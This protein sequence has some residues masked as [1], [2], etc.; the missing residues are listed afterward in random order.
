VEDGPVLELSLGK[1][2][3]LDLTINLSSTLFDVKAVGGSAGVRTHQEF[4]G[5]VLETLEFL[6]V[7][8]KLQVPKLLFLNALFICLEVIHQVLDLLYFGFGVSVNDL[9]EILHQS[10][11]CTHSISEAR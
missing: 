3:A 4:T 9:G 5:L 6:G 2:L 10:K 8:I 7:L 1:H 11:I